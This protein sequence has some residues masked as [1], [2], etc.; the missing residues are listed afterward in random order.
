MD[1]GSTWYLLFT[2]ALATAFAWFLWDGERRRIAPRVVI[3]DMC[4]AALL[5][6]VAGAR[7]MHVLVEPLPGH[8]L[9]AGEVAE[10]H[11]LLPEL[12]DEVRGPLVTALSRPDVPASWSFVA[13]MPDGPARTAA[14]EAIAADPERVPARLWYRALPGEVLAFWKGGLAFL[15]GVGLAA[16]ACCVVAWRHRA[17]VRDLCDLGAPAIAL[18]D[19]IGRLGC[20]LSGCCYGAVCEPAWWSVQPSWYGPPMGGVPRYPTALGEMALGLTLFG[21]LLAWQRRRAFRGE[22]L[23]AFVV[24]YAPGRFVLETLRD[25]PR[26]GAAGLSSSQWLGLALAVPAALI[27]AYGR[28]RGR[29]R[30]PIPLRG[31]GAEPPAA[32]SG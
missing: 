30:P 4:L 1:P 20:F 14:L 21:V 15:G 25:D 5:F 24:L 13:R 8:S 27:W 3:V 22:V 23:C 7:L 29:G 16:A 10:L 28:W 11:A 26:G 32:N 12:D 17:P 6:G 9:P 18:A 19:A 31:E 2:L